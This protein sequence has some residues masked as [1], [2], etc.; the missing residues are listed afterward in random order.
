[1]LLLQDPDD[2]DVS[3]LIK[4]LINGLVVFFFIGLPILK[5]LLESRKE[6]KAKETER[7]RRSAPDES[8]PEGT[9]E[10]A[11]PS[12][13]ELLRGE[14]PVEQTAATPPP[15]PSQAGSRIP[16]TGTLVSLD[17][18]AP[19]M[20]SEENL[21]SEAGNDEETLAEEAIARR[22]REEFERQQETA[23]RQRE[24]GSSQRTSVEP[25]YTAGVDLSA[26]R[27]GDLTTPAPPSALARRT[28]RTRAPQMNLAR[29]IVMSEILGPPVGLDVLG[30]RRATRPLSM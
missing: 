17:Q 18:G 14:V 20:L 30:E 16:T 15:I 26:A 1:M 7:E 6:R 29:A 3:A 28:T 12:W 9:T 25:V 19:P 8:T 13:E 11:R 5:G 22:E 4:K 24:A 2:F 10:S 21:E 23:R 27:A